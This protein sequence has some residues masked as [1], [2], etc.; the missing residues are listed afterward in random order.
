MAQELNELVSE[1]IIEMR[2]MRQ[3]TDANL[4]ALRQEMHEQK[5]ILQEHSKQ[6]KDHGDQLKALSNDNLR[7]E[8]IAIE[9]NYTMKAI[10][11]KLNIHEQYGHR[12]ERLEDAVFKVS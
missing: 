11:D 3:E 12:I 8:T 2:G 6:L 4:K 7:L 9:Q 5:M 1:L 10:S